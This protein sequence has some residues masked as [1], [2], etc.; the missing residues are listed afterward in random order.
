MIR[1]SGDACLRGKQINWVNRE[2]ETIK[3]ILFFGF[4]TSKISSFQGDFPSY[5]FQ[6]RIVIVLN[7]FD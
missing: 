3:L 5:H 2:K 1:L 4:V 6:A 7:S